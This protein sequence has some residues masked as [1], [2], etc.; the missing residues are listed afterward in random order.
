[1]HPLIGYVLASALFAIG[2]YGILTR[3]NAILQLAAVEIM[4]AAVHITLVTAD[5]SHGAHTGQSFAMFIVV[6]AA[7]EV[8]VGLALVLRLWRARSSID[9][10]HLPQE[11]GVR[12]TTERAQNVP[13]SATTQ[14]GD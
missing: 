14:A 8:G 5:V 4:L 10:D 6:I 7:A 9:T 1:M 11:S 12:M 2:V 3:R 13:P